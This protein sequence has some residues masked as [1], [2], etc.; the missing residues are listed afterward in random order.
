MRPGEPLGSFEFALGVVGFIRGCWVHSGAPFV[1]PGWL[2]SFGC[3]LGSLCISGVVGVRPCVIIR[4][5]C[6]L[7]GGHWVHPGSLGS[8]PRALGV[9]GFFRCH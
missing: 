3:A 9:V 8:F 7:R 4:F 5:S 2:V 1:N 6:M